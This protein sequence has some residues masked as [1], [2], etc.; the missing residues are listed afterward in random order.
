MKRYPHAL[1]ILL[2]VFIII[3]GG[4]RDNNTNKIS[5]ESIVISP[6][7]HMSF[8][9]EK[10]RAI[11]NVDKQSEKKRF[12]LICPDLYKFKDACNVYLL[13]SGSS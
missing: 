6:N 13:K 12:E 9:Q 1:I 3:T 8:A 2:I 10:L 7:D 4:V 5:K 11:N